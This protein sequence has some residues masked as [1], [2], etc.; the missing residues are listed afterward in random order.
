MKACWRRRYFLDPENTGTSSVSP[1]ENIGT[2]LPVELVSF[3]AMLDGQTLELRW[4]TASETNN[5]GFEIQH[6]AT[7]NSASW[8]VR[9]FIEG[10]GTTLEAQS[11]TYRLDNLLAGKHRFR[12]K[13]IDFDGTFEYSPE[14]EVNVGIPMSYHLSA[15]YPNPFNPETHF[16]LSTARAQQ[17]EVAVYDVVGRQVATL[18]EGML[19]AQTTRSFL[20]EANSLPSGLY[21]I[22]VVGEHFITSQTITLLK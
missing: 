16:S 2:N 15:A 8:D 4:E 22:R 17:V 19:E 10:R 18:F 20:F 9:G 7:D 12:L 14:V 13:Q 21:L 3:D 1:H 6:F 5:A 11:Y